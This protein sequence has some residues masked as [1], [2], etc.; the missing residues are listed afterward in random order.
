MF[1]IFNDFSK[2]SEKNYD[3]DSCEVTWKKCRADKVTIKTIILYLEKSEDKYLKEGEME[4]MGNIQELKK[5]LNLLTKEI[6]SESVIRQHITD[7]LKYIDR[8]EN[9]EIVNFDNT[10][11]NHEKIDIDIDNVIKINDVIT[12]IKSRCGSGKTQFLKR[13]IES[14]KMRKEDNKCTKIRKKL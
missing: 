14:M 6:E 2:R 8:I 7:D 1:N 9:V 13:V 12:C 4:K 11:I 5:E 3:Y 10:Y